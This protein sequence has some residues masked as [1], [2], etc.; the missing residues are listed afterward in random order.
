MSLTA[1]FFGAAELEVRSPEPER[2][3]NLCA[4]G[5]LPFWDAEPLDRFTLRLFVRKRDVRR[6]LALAGRAGAETRILRES[7]LP[8]LT[9]KLRRRVLLP[10]GALLL[11]ACSLWSSLHI[12]EIEVT[13]NETVSD[14]EILSA[15][16]SVGVGVGSFWPEFRQDLIRSRVMVLLPELSWMTVNVSGSRAEVIVRERRPIPALFDRDA[17]TEIIAGKPGLLTEVRVYRGNRKMTAGQTASAGDVLVSASVPGLITAPRSVH[18]RAD[19]YAR[20]WYTLTAVSPLSESRKTAVKEQKRVFSLVFFGKRINFYKSSG[21]FTDTCDK[22]IVEHSAALAGVFSLPLSLVETRLTQWE[23]QPAVKEREEQTASLRRL[24][25][26][27]L[28]A[29]I[30]GDGS[31]NRL[32]FSCSEENGLL[33]LT[34]HAE[35]TEQIGRERALPPETESAGP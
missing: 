6:C 4:E 31:A 21:I 22:I 3:L 19:V 5:S 20:T 30:G 7:G 1:L 23:T 8:V 10:A 9:K 35:C 26:K 11:L 17:P 25:E 13:G 28:Y 14:W 32:I 2:F 34:L 24:L 33:C 18:A 16:D 15:L 27:T 12:W 29:E